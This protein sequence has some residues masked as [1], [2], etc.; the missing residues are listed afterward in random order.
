MTLKFGVPNKGRLNER[1]VELLTKAGLDLGEDFG[2][3]LYIKARN[4]DVEV[5]FL[6][7]QDIPEFIATGAIDLGITGQDQVAESGHTLVDR[8][9]LQFGFCHMALAVP[10]ESGI[11][12]A[13]QVKDGSRIATSYP[14]ITKRYFQSLGKL[15]NVIVVTGA[16]EVMPYLGIADYIVDL[17]STG[18]TLKMNRM[19]EAGRIID[20]QACV[21]TSEE[22]LKR[23]GPQIDELADSIESVIT[24]ESKKYLMANVP[25]DRMKDAEGIIPG[26]EGPTILEI[27]GNPEYVA[28]HAVIDSKDTLHIISDLKKIGAKG[29]L[30][31]EIERLVNRWRPTAA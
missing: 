2:R 23:Y 21:F 26:L 4:Q 28:I 30:T 22:A 10:E 25:R 19:V 27:A 29:I 14:N 3:K 16:A 13:S 17:V 31:T 7:A 24:A 5:L 18:S 9:D 6:R 11:T 1:A 20:S 15:V 12:D 8:L